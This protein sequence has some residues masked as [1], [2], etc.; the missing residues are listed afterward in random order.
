[1]HHRKLEKENKQLK[2]MHHEK[3]KIRHLMPMHLQKEKRKKVIKCTYMQLN[4]ACP[5]AKNKH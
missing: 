5:K 2:C 3:R 1:M 4:L